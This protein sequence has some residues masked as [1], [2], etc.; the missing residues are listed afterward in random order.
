MLETPLLCLGEKEEKENTE[1][2]EGHPV[3]LIKKGNKGQILSCNDFGLRAYAI[4]KRNRRRGGPQKSLQAGPGSCGALCWLDCTAG[5]GRMCEKGKLPTLRQLETDGI[6]S[7]LWI[8][9]A[10]CVER[11]KISQL[12]LK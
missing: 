9:E 11:P 1:K 4:P 12:L 8:S 2:P 10:G 3:T 6:L 5:E 7:F